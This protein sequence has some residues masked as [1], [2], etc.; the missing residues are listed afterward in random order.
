MFWQV[1]ALAQPFPYPYP[2]DPPL[3]V[4][5][6]ANYGPSDS[7]TVNFNFPA[8][9]VRNGELIETGF[10]IKHFGVWD[11]TAK[12]GTATDGDVVA[13][14][15]ATMR[16]TESNT[17]IDYSYVGQRFRVDAVGN[18]P[19][20]QEFTNTP[21]GDPTG[22]PPTI[23]WRG[24][25]FDIRN[26]DAYP[27]NQLGP[28][29]GGLTI[30]SSYQPVKGSFENFQV[31]GTVEFTVGQAFRPWET[32]EVLAKRA[33]PTITPSGHKTGMEVNPVPRFG[34]TPEEAA[35]L[36]QYDHFNWYQ[37]VVGFRIGVSATNPAGTPLTSAQMAAYEASH[38]A[39]E[40]GVGFGPDP[41]PYGNPGNVAD[42]YLL[43][44]DE[45]EVDDR[46]PGYRW[47][48][49][50]YGLHFEDYP[51]LLRG[52]QMFFMTALAGVRK[53]HTYDLLYKTG[54]PN[55]DDFVF[56][57]SYLQDTDSTGTSILRGNKNPA[58]GGGGTVTLLGTGLGGQHFRYL[59]PGDANDDGK[60][61][62]ND[63]VIVAQHYN[64]TIAGNFDVG[65]FN[66]DGL[67][68]FN[69]LVLLA[70]NYN[71]TALPAGGFAGAPP[72]FA[73]D[74][75]AAFASVPEPAVVAPAF[76]LATALA[77]RTRGR[78]TSGGWTRR[79]CWGTW[80]RRGRCSASRRLAFRQVRRRAAPPRPRQL[81]RFFPTPKLRFPATP[82]AAFHARNLTG[83][84]Q[85]HSR[86]SWR[87][88]SIHRFR[89]R[90][91]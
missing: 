6:V 37:E 65:D 87:D 21:F 39:A 4:V 7:V 66:Y 46:E 80:A 25:P 43:Y 3:P 73:A 11:V 20:S 91:C 56:R 16:F 40:E 5:R 44:W 62:F 54:I 49:N 42:R 24:I 14:V 58:L 76:L 74:L 28:F 9:D 32:H 68:D 41:A 59:L 31:R 8:S 85:S 50:N 55:A 64:T 84:M 77:G 23:P 86:L 51:N 69:D 83:S 12:R 60:V 88:R 70:Q 27:T 63:L 26:P 90:I 72:E 30:T 10:G 81:G 19:A 47:E 1:A 29:S 75:A 35:H 34:F 67:V 78:R 36:S 52:N 53:D 71:T 89:V 57:W 79:T 2:Y 82:G 38:S 48:D 18:P 22:A 61:D 45:K 15:D 33:T 17:G 13:R